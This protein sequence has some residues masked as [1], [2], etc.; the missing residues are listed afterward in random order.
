MRVY[1]LS[2]VLSSWGFISSDQLLVVVCFVVIVVFF[3]QALFFRVFMI[4]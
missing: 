2:P 3:G 1:K 4:E